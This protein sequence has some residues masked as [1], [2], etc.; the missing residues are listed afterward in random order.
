[1]NILVTG[2]SGFFGS[3]IVRVL[4][5]DT[6]FTLNRNN[7]DF[8]YDLSQS[9]PEFNVDFDIVSIE[10]IPDQRYYKIFNGRPEEEVERYVQEH[11]N[12]IMEVIIKLKVVK[13]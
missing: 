3:T 13:E 6:I 9:I 5:S 10:N 2:S 8:Q 1:M 4:N 7:G 12:I 11:N